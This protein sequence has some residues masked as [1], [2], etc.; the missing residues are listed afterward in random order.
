LRHSICAA[1]ILYLKLVAPC[2]NGELTAR[3]FS[4][5]G[6]IMTRAK[7]FTNP[8]DQAIHDTHRMYVAAM[9]ERLP[10]ISE[11]S[12]ERYLA[13]LRSLTD[14]LAIPSKPLSE[15]ISETMAEAAPLLFQA[16]Q[17]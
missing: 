16:M 7:K 10:T 4:R 15:I 6:T 13:V 17:H 3:A 12:R 14:K 2:Y 9:E 5:A 8:V 1:R 11:Q